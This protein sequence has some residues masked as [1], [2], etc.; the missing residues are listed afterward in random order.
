MKTT[1]TKI[2]FDKYD[3]CFSVSRTNPVT[4]QT[5]DGQPALEA[6]WDENGLAVKFY[7]S[8]R[9]WPLVLT[10]PHASNGNIL[11][12]VR[13]YRVELW[14]GGVL[15]DEEWPV[16]TFGVAD[17]VWN[18][19]VEVKPYTEDPTPL[20]TVLG[21]FRNA[22]GWRPEENVFVG[23]CMPYSDSERYHV[24]YLKDRHHH[25]SKYGSGAH[26][27]SHISTADFENWQIHPDVVEIDEQ[28]EG[29]ICTGSH[30]EYNGKH[31]LYYT[32]R[33]CDGSPAPI[34][35]SVS[36]DGYHYEKDRAFRMV[37]SDAYCKVSARDP[38]VVLA[39]DGV[40][41][42]FVTTTLLSKEKGCLAHLTSSDGNVWCEEPTPI[43]IAP[44][45]DQPECPD[46]FKYHDTYYLVFSH[47]GYGQYLYSKKPFTDWQKPENSH[48][49]CESVPKMALW[50][51]KIV[52][53]GFDRI[54]GYAGNMTFLT[55]EPGADELFP[56]QG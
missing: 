54:G 46:Y 11:L 13:P 22:E 29:S 24:I 47:G 39:E 16:G 50:K 19:P 18:T 31:Y 12:R 48:I 43:Y 53:V 9:T 35:R 28:W 17:A 44:D 5:P 21:T 3:I 33:A 6:V 14:A 7:T 45:G 23:D 37:L 52:F 56:K 27:W 41:H 51:G 32:I 34:C 38:K 42:M 4:A 25:N 20:P 10:A 36:S 40:L 26:Q 30:I 1:V 8:F 15:C 55:L 49:P 2:S